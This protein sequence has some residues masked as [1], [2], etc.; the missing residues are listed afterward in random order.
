MNGH[1]EKAL[2]SILVTLAE[3]E[4]DV[5]DVQDL[6]AC[7]PITETVEGITTDV[8]F[9][10]DWK[11]LLAILVVLIVNV[12]EQGDVVH[13]LQ[14][15]LPSPLLQTRSVHGALTDR[16]PVAIDLVTLV[17]QLVMQEKGSPENAEV[18]IMII[19]IVMK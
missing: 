12:M 2:V 5:S 13:R 4:T 15:P 6:K 10:Q 1:S 14:Q 17:S 7:V 8:S 18:S 19:I 11:A 16:A 9:V 3:I